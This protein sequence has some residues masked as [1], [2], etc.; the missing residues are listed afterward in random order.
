MNKK[1]IR[2][3]DAA[4]IAVTAV[5][6]AGF[7]FP[8]YFTFISAFKTNGE[9]LRSPIALPSALR[10]DNFIYLWKKT[11]IPAAALR[12]AFLTIVSTLC[13]VLVIPMSSYALER[14]KTR[15]SRFLYIFFLSGMMIPFQVYMIPLFRQLKILG[16]FGTLQGPIFVYVS[17]AVAFGTLLYSSFIKTVPKEIEESACLDGYRSFQIFWK[18]V[19]PL[20]APCTASMVILQSLNIWNDFLMPLMVMPANRPKTINVEIYAFIGEFQVRWDVLFSGTLIS[21]VPVIVVF[22]LLQKYFV[23]GIMAGTLKG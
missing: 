12:S 8:I 23:S 21:M 20:L 4:I 13:M 18:I 10:F 7:F 14:R 11:N 3:S 19:F 16:L 9:I 5:L 15:F 2:A 6:A 1:K 17:G 22:A